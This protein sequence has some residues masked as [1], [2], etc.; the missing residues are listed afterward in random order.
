MQRLL[1]PPSIGFAPPELEQRHSLPPNNSSPREPGSGF[2][3]EPLGPT[4]WVGY[5]GNY[6]QGSTYNHL[7]VP[8]PGQRWTTNHVYSQHPMPPGYYANTPS[9]PFPPNTPSTPT[10]NHHIN[11]ESGSVTSPVDP[12]PQHTNENSTNIYHPANA[13]LYTLCQAAMMSSSLQENTNPYPNYP[14]NQQPP[15]LNLP[16]PRA[17]PPY[18]QYYQEPSPFSHSGSPQH[19]PPPP[20]HSMQMT[21]H[22]GQ[23]SL[24]MCGP[25]DT[26]HQ[27]NLSP[28]FLNRVST[29][30]VIQNDDTHPTPSYLPLL[31]PSGSVPPGRGGNFSHQ[32]IPTGNGGVTENSNQKTLNSVHNNHISQDPSND[33]LNPSSSSSSVRHHH[34]PNTVNQDGEVGPGTNNGEV[35]PGT[36]NGEAGPGINDGEVGHGIN[37]RTNHLPPP[38]EQNQSSMKNVAPVVKS[39]KLNP[40]RHSCREQ[41][42][43]EQLVMDGE[44]TCTA[45]DTEGQE[46]AYDCE[47]DAGTSFVQNAEEP[48]L[49]HQNSVSGERTDEGI[50]MKKA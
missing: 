31:L 38:Y 35:G 25:S 2:H 5:G 37:N 17:P 33:Q 30:G 19:P 34:P 8:G 39:E 50:G 40:R 15:Q 7:P 1:P 43:E 27:T 47:D 49:P 22:H 32:Q 13:G 18:I 10:H 44:N 9:S 41:E 12:S 14:T 3:W 29:N 11:H 16:Q 45:E 24:V 4:A 6:Q 42:E 46:M 26:S 23:Q 28:S 48:K 21:P 20:Y 36:N